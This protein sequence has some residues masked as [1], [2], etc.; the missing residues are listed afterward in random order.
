MNGIKHLLGIDQETRG[1]IQAGAAVVKR[2]SQ[3]SQQAAA[4]NAKAALGAI[5]Q[6]RAAA[7]EVDDL[8][9]QAIDPDLVIPPGD[10]DLGLR[11]GDPA[12]AGGPAGAS[13]AI[14]LDTDVSSP[15]QG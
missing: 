11:P 5:R 6:R 15:T 10:P 12:P 4:S 7:Q 9:R 13:G 14:R 2:W 1:P 3:L 8:L